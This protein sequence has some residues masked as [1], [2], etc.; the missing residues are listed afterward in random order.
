M[1]RTWLIRHDRIVLASDACLVS[2]VAFGLA[3]GLL[4]LSVGSREPAGPI[5]AAQAI[6]ILGTVLAGPALAWRLRRRPATWRA[7][8]GAFAGMLCVVIGS[9]LLF[10][11]GAAISWVLS[12]VTTSELASPGRAEIFAFAILAGFTGAAMVVGADLVQG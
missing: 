9:Q 10:A 1:P 7:G 8:L 11:L 12:P 5:A 2:S 3:S 4:A 6:G